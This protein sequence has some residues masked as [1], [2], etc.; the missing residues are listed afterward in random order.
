LEKR[1]LV[2]GKNPFVGDFL[3][4]A[5]SGKR[6]RVFTAGDGVEGLF[7]FGVVQP[8][9]VILDVEESDTLQRLRSLSAVP[10]IVLAD[11]RS[12]PESINLGAD[13]Y[14]TRPP[15]LR[16]LSAKVRASFRRV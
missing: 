14:V 16:E 13:F 11:E 9:I 10:I 1:V 3:N 2:I 4:H 12:G 8:H 6:L 5:F 7:Q 15:N